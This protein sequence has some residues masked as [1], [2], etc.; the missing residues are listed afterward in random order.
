MFRRNHM[1]VRTTRAELSMAWK[2]ELVE[3]GRD[4]RHR[5]DAQQ[6]KFQRLVDG[7]KDQPCRDASRCLGL[8]QPLKILGAWDVAPRPL[9]AGEFFQNGKTHH[10]Q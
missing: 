7:H 8:V 9:N 1:D 4:R 5:K 2:S 10:L 6:R 3:K